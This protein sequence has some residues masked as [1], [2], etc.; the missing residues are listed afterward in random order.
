MR[1]PVEQNHVDSKKVVCAVFVQRLR[2]EDRMGGRLRR[3]DRI[4]EWLVHTW[5][6]RRKAFQELTGLSI[7]DP[8]VGFNTED[9]EPL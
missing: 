6:G 3:E 4:Q 5:E 7:E 2:T 1:N 9:W 8:K